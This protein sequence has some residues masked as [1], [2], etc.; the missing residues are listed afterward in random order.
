MQTVTLDFKAVFGDEEFA[1]GQLYAD[2]GT[3]PTLVT[4]QD[5]RFYVTDVRL[6]NADG[7]EIPLSIEENAPYQGGGV[8]LLDFEDGTGS[9]INGDSATNATLTGSI[10][11]GDYVGIAFSTAVPVELNHADPTTLPGPLQAGAMTWGWLFGYKF[12]VAEVAQVLTETETV[13]AGADAAAPVAGLGL[14][15]LGSTECVNEFGA[16]AGSD[17]AAPPSTACG[18]QNR[19]QIYLPDFTLD[20][21]IVVD[22]SALFGATDLTSVS[23][24]HSSGDACPSMFESAGIS[25]ESGDALSEQTL[26][27]VQ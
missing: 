13:D 20:S 27:A 19:N 15:H 10:A 11:A 5:L 6:I 1:C 26:F 21:S 2:Q 14:V 25:F 22:L 4:P 8:A 3:P 7:D 18:K 9:C 17:F 12:F 16:D 23:M 24:C